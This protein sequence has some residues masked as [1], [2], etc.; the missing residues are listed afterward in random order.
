MEKKKPTRRL[1][2]RLSQLRVWLSHPRLRY[3]GLSTALVA[4]FLAALVLLN[5]A[6]TNLER[7]HG[8]RVD[9]SFNALTTQSQAT[10]DILAD[11]PYPVHIYALFERGEE[12]LPLMELLNR[13]SAA[14]TLVTWEQTSLSLNPMLQE[15]FAGATA[16][17]AVAND[18]LIVYCEATDRFRV[19]S[20]KNFLSLS[21]DYDAG[22]YVSAG[23]TYE[24]EITSA[25]AYVTRETIPMVYFIQGHGELDENATAVL[26]ALLRTNHYDVRYDRLANLTLQ[27]ED[28]VCLLSPVLDLSDAELEQLNAFAQSS[29]GFLLTCDYT[30]P[31]AQMP[32]WRALLRSYGFLPLDGVVVASQEEPDSY[33]NGNR[34]SLLPRM[35]PAEVTLDLMSNGSTLLLLPGARAFA[36]PDGTDENLLVEALL[37]SGEK[38]YLHDISSSTL[39]LAKQEGDPEGPFPLALEARRFTSKGEISRAVVLGCSPLLT[40]EQVYAMCNAQEFILRVM[41]FVLHSA[42]TNLNIMAKALVRPQLSAASLTLG[43]VVLTFAPLLVLIGALVV[44]LPRRRL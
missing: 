22:K 7:K 32:N 31:L 36:N 38:S 15:R 17:N 41:N 23:L 14:S 12:D 42:P 33:Y 1:R 8:W 5:L 4:L 28:L 10:L 34:I 20:P 29:G 25:I 27:P 30:D 18:S 2:A 21:Y 11:L 43:S 3:G 26:A 37:S 6:C 19:L 39:S 44:L 9:Y 35:V 40:S 13:Y 16:G 24:S